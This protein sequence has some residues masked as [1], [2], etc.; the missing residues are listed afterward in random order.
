MEFT[1]NVMNFFLVHDFRRTFQFGS[2][3]ARAQIGPLFSSY[4]S[5]LFVGLVSC[6]SLRYIGN[7]FPGERTEKLSL[8]FMTLV[9]IKGL[10]ALMGVACHKGAD[11]DILN[12]F[13]LLAGTS[14]LYDVCIWH[15]NGMSSTS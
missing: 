15:S 12:V 11:G 7:H 5:D 4:S 14:L 10:R 2:C 8:V 1:F 3:D 9:L 6:R 13:D